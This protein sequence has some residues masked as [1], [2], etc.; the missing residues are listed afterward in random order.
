MIY[1]MTG[2]TLQYTIRPY[3][4]IWM[5]AQVFNT[6]PD[7]IMQLNPGIN[8]TNLQ[9]GQVITIAPGYQSFPL[10][11]SG[12]LM[13]ESSEM[14]FM[15]DMDDMFDEMIGSEL[16]DLVNFFR[17]LWEQHIT[18]TSNVMDAIIFELPLQEQVT[19]RLLRNA[20]DFANA[21]MPFYGEEAA[22][23]FA[24]LFTQ[25]IT[26]AAEVIQAAKAGDTDALTETNTRWYQNADQI[27]AFLANINPNWSEEDWSAMLEEHLN[28]LSQRVNDMVMQNY[29]EAVNIY[30]DIQLQALEM[31]DMMAEG[32]YMQFPM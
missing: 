32:I 5:L 2:G 17:M 29:E 31:A 3:D 9:V 20:Q 6:T 15:D 19:Q 27:A 11:P 30:D 14:D 25:H 4:T 22:Q 18:W 21:L 28:L 7:A 1:I 24:D 12:Q 23:A 16:M 13:G 26:I 8:P 10:T